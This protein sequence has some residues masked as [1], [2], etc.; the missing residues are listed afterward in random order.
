MKY[1]NSVSSSRKKERKHFFN[2]P[3]H[4]R[5]MTMSSHLSKMLQKKYNIKSIPIRKNDEVKIVRGSMKG[6]IGKVIQCHRK[7]F[8][9]FIEK[10]AR[11]K[12]GRSISYIP[13]SPSNVVVVN[14]SITNERK[15][16]FL[17]R[18]N[19]LTPI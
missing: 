15:S 14:L 8:S 2:L 17:K 7:N 16:F 9:I 18:N 13:I 4:Q 1:A 11:F 3:S 5:R 10:I 12:T 6:K 19:N